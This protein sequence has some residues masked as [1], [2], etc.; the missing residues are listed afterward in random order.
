MH[1]LPRTKF[2]IVIACLQTAA[3]ACYRYRTENSARRRFVGSNQVIMARL[4]YVDDQTIAAP[5]GRM[6]YPTVFIRMRRLIP[7]WWNGTIAS[8]RRTPDVAFGSL[9]DKP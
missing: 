5:F 1:W 4:S 9:A 2:P 7:R 6:Q 8:L 3:A